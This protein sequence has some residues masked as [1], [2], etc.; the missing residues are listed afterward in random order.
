ELGVISS[1][2]SL[3]LTDEERKKIKEYEDKCEQIFRRQ[4]T[5]EAERIL[6]KIYNNSYMGSNEKQFMAGCKTTMNELVEA[7][8]KLAQQ[9]DLSTV[10]SQRIASEII[11]KITEEK[12]HSLNSRGIQ[13]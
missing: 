12:K 8:V 7:Q 5:K 11:D 10:K 9:A 4:Y 1:D 2:T 6:S 3:M 13:K